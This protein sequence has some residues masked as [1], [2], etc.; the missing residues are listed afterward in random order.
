MTTAVK[1]KPKNSDQRYFPRWEVKNLIIY[2]VA[3]DPKLHEAHSH[4]L[5]G[6]GVCFVSHFPLKQNQKL[7]L[8]IYLAGGKNVEA[9]GKLIWSRQTPKGQL[10]GVSFI[11]MGTQV[12]DLILQHAFE[13]KKDEFVILR[14]PLKGLRKKA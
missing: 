2:R 9:D 4:D 3:G 5:S 10:V 1:N 8:K 14:K 7:K 12:Q 11:N 6:A 13:I